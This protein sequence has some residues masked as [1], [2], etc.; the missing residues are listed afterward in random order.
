MKWLRR[1]LGVVLF[2]FVWIILNDGFSLLNFFVGIGVSV[3][4]VIV[5]GKLLGFDYF[6]TFYI[7]PIKGMFY[8]FF[9]IKEVFISGI[10]MTK[11]II[12]GKKKPSFVK[13]SLNRKLNNSPF[14][15]N[16]IAASITLTPGTITAKS[17]DG[18][19]TVLCINSEKNPNPAQPFESRMIEIAKLQAERKSHE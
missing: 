11:V 8:M 14:L 15:Q 13:V 10:K 2:T 19:I 16:I 18:V 6:S 9:M 1:L 5:T 4:A 7:P 17:E 3:V 12:T